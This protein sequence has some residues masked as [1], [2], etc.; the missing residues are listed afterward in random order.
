MYKG[1][2]HDQPLK[3]IFLI[4]ISALHLRWVALSDL[5]QKHIF[6]ASELS[7]EDAVPQATS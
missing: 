2:G 3:L 7:F 6:Q 4:A 1:R 5:F